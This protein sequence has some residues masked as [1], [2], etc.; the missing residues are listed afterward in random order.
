MKIAFESNK[1]KIARRMVEVLDYFD[2][3]HKKA[4]VMDIVRRY[5]RPQSSTSELLSTLVELG[6]LHKDPVSR[7]YELTPR[8][9]FLGASAQP[10][11]L[12]NGQLTETI[13]RL[14][15]QTGLG[16]AVFGMVGLNVQVF[17]H[18]S[19]RIGPMERT[20]RL[21]SCGQQ[22]RLSN[23]AAGWLL[24]S[25]VA[26]PRRDGMMRRLNAE[27]PDNA[28]FHPAE[29]SARLADC[30]RN[31]AAFGPT[32]FDTSAQLCCVLLPGQPDGQP[33]ALGLLAPGGMQP[34]A[35]ALSACLFD[36]VKAAGQTGT[37]AQLAALSSAA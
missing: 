7:T 34:D 8:A 9:A 1:A 36:A 20:P 16:V 10:E 29:M 27:A 6:L 12:R 19:A 32:G 35:Q 30:V 22:D 28:R 11:I 15:A 13:D 4:T 24:L 37:G 17:S 25:T 3:Q 21:L 31:A 23:S 33:I 2:D 5:N 26:Q 14:S 18:R